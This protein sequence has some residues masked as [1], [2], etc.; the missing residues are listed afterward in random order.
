MMS[1][2]RIALSRLLY[3][4]VMLFGGG[5]GKA[6]LLPVIPAHAGMTKG[7]ARPNPPP[8]I[9]AKAGI[10]NRYRYGSSGTCASGFPPS[11]E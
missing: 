5:G 9:P 8:V 10:Q 11:R 3:A 1:K 4:N 2:S 6:C 7:E